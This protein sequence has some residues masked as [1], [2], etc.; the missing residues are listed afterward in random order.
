MQSIGL[1]MSELAEAHNNKYIDDMMDWQTMMKKV[2]D[3]LIPLNH[4]S[5]RG[6]RFLLECSGEEVQQEVHDAMCKGLALVEELGAEYGIFG[7]DM[8]QEIS[9]WTEE[10]LEAA[11]TCVKQLQVHLQNKP[12]EYLTLLQTLTNAFTAALE[13]MKNA[14]KEA[15]QWG[16]KAVD[17]AGRG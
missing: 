12:S 4:A 2:N 8:P 5:V 10:K 7:P 17:L 9:D 16:K 14:N 13:L 11:V 15:C 1:A 3:D 6:E